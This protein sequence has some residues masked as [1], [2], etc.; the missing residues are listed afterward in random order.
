[1]DAPYPLER[2]TVAELYDYNEDSDLEDEERDDIE[3]NDAGGG[4]GSEHKSFPIGS[5][6]LPDANKLA[7]YFSKGVPHMFSYS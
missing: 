2:P 5:I 3:L 7:R 6:K 4:N 1:M